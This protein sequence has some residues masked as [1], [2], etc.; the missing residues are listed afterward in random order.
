MCAVECKKKG[1][2]VH[3]FRPQQT[4]THLPTG[5]SVH[6]RTRSELLYFPPAEK[7]EK[8]PI[9]QAEHAHDASSHA[10]PSPQ[11][12]VG[13]GEGSGV[14]NGVVGSGVGSGVGRG[15]GGSVNVGSGVGSD[16]GENWNSR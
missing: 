7:F 14:G 4:Q 6:V 12:G 3:N 1:E 2:E 13:S 16:V 8:R 11:N 15:V 9:V 5:H 10:Y